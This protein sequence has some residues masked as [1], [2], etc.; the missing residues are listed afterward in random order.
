MPAIQV[1]AVILFMPMTS[2]QNVLI[3]TFL[4]DLIQL[5]GSCIF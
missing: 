4:A 2:S 3:E 5:I 1:A